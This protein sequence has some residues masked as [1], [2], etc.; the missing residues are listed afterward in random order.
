MKNNS[1]KT[2]GQMSVVLLIFIKMRKK[3]RIFMGGIIILTT[4]SINFMFSRESTITNITFDNIDA[5]AE[6]E[7]I[8]PDATCIYVGAF[9][10]GIDSDGI[11]GDHFGLSAIQE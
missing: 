3:A 11:V 8:D 1:I 7:S 5:L 10:F 6:N 4:L 9:C 2:M